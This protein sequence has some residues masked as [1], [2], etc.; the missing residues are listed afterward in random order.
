MIPLR[1]RSSTPLHYQF[2]LSLLLYGLI[3]QI[4]KVQSQKKPKALNNSVP[5]FF[6]FGDSTVD[7]GNN[8]YLKTI[9][10]SNFLPYG[11]DF[12]NQIP[13]GRFTNGRLANDFIASYVGVKDY[14]PP[15]LDPGLGMEDLLTG[16]SFA[17]AGSGYDPLTPQI[18]NVMPL[19]R[20]LEF[21]KEYKTRVQAEIGKE[22]SKDLIRN[23]LYLVSAGTNDFV[24]NYFAV[25]VRR[26][27]YNMPGYMGFLLQQF[28]DFMQG[29]LELGARRIGVVGLPPMGC[30]PI[31]ITL[32][33]DASVPSVL[34][35]GCIDYF[36]LLSNRHNELLQTKLHD[37][38]VGPAGS[39]ARI[40][41]MDVY[42]PLYE[43]IHQGSKFGFEHVT[44]GCC[45][46]G[47]L[48]ASI[49]CNPESSVCSDASKYVFWDSIHPSEKTYYLLF[50]ALRPQIDFLIS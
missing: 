29:L 19:T 12:P 30:L 5:A 9:F 50:Q 2:L 4:P 14:L 16:V 34:E 21:F 23:S 8:N 37:L 22:R 10:K 1:K 28:D 35:R 17:S 45:G 32:N 7:P 25:P 46:T 36:S 3:L 47:L 31:V 6:V 26:K 11:R 41:Y 27:V 20:Q 39:G 38:R 43:V 44:G 15:Y 48:E 18:S 49:L 33:S 24:V 40:A 42:G 13:T